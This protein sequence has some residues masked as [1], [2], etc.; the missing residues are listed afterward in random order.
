MSIKKVLIVEDDPDVRL[1]LEKFLSSQNFEC[2]SADTVEH[3]LE[4]LKEIN[5]HVVLLDLGLPKASGIAFMQ[6]AQG[7]VGEENEVP[8]VIVLSGHKDQEIVDYA[9]SQGA[10]GFI[11]KPFEMKQVTSLIWECL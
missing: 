11:G 3:A 4:L 1:L 7:W 10:C 6:N 5:P 8:P 2:S 9:L